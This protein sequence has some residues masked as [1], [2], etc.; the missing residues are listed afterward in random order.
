MYEEITQKTDVTTR[1]QNLKYDPTVLGKAAL[2]NEQYKVKLLNS[3]KDV[4]EIKYYG[5]AS[6][7]FQ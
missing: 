7:P 3:K 1:L 6:D 4:G 5:A 2:K